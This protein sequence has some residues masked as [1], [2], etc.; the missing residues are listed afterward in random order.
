MIK[1]H[2]AVLESKSLW[3]PSSRM[4]VQPFD[5]QVMPFA[6]NTHSGSQISVETH[7]AVDVFRRLS[8]SVQ[9]HQGTTN[10]EHCRLLSRR[11]Q[12]ARNLFEEG[13]DLITREQAR[14][15]HAGISA[16]SRQIADSG[17]SR[18][19]RR[20][21]SGIFDSTRVDRRVA[22]DHG[23]SSGL[24]LRV[25]RGRAIPASSANFSATAASNVSIRVDEDRGGSG[26]IACATKTGRS[27]N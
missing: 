12:L 7:N 3:V 6:D 17:I 13:P 8:K 22:T 23:L 10:H 26:R 9:R 19:R 16:L 25:H 15:C 4:V 24:R 20:N 27:V 18:P 1:E 14:R 21:W 2:V 11:I 5:R